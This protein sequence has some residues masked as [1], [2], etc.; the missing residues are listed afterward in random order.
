MRHLIPHS[1]FL[2]SA[3]RL[4]MFF[5]SS[6]EIGYQKIKDESN[7]LIIHQPFLISFL[8]LLLHLFLIFQPYRLNIPLYVSHTAIFLPSFVYTFLPLLPSR[9]ICI[10]FHTITLYEFKCSL[11]PLKMKNLNVFF[12]YQNRSKE[13][14]NPFSLFERRSNPIFD[15]L[16]SIFLLNFSSYHPKRSFRTTFLLFDFF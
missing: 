15:L 10:Y 1:P 16:I 6:S 12:Q 4:E 13:K 5:S 3:N 9:K 8:N 11:S 14:N 2:H 7:P